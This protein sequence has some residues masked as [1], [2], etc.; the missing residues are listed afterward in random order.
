MAMYAIKDTTL[1]ALG[2]AVRN[3]AG[4]Y[5]SVDEK[6]EPFYEITGY[7]TDLE[8]VGYDSMNVRNWY[9]TPLIDFRTIPRADIADKWYIEYSY[10]CLDVAGPMQSRIV[11]TVGDT[12]VGDE[13]INTMK[14]IS[15]I[16]VGKTVP[17]KSGNTSGNVLDAWNKA[18]LEVGMNPDYD[19][20]GQRILFNV[21]IWACDANDKFIEL[22]KY[23]PLEMA[24]KV[25]E[26]MTIPDEALN[27]TG[28][29]SYRFTNNNWNWF[30]EQAGDKI[31]TNGITAT[32][33]M[34]SQC[35]K[36]KSIP[37]EININNSSY[38]DLSYMFDYCVAL[39]ELPKINNAYPSGL[40]YFCRHCHNVREIP[41]DYF[42][43]WNFN[44]LHS[45]SYANMSYMFAYMNSVRKIP[46]NV[47]KNLWSPATTSSYALYCYGFH[48]CYYL[49][50]LVGLPVP[51]AKYTSNVF[52]N[53]FD[54]CHR[55]KDV[56]FQ[57]NEDGTP[58]VAPWNKQ[59]IN[60]SVN[61]G[62][63]PSSSPDFY[64]SGIT[65]DKLITTNAEYEALKDDPDATPVYLQWSRYNHDSAVRTINSL[66]DCS[67]TGTNTI[68]FSGSSGA[69]TDG[70]AI[71]TL[72]EEEIAVATAKGWTVSM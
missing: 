41:E 64:N 52:S 16:A 27:I 8:F 12:P 51:P 50:E 30:I 22:N 11:F 23:T 39:E 2:D 18:Y 60:L 20:Q 57:T 72:T 29:C 33:S 3:K 35:D 71:N 68:K 48:S 1:T 55:L 14:Y 25:N 54:Q 15:I 40:G 62:Y 5:I 63:N 44:R 19:S 10:E 32:V 28:D 24:E 56:I 37:F 13:L 61:V 49:D 6:G 59:T 34:F 65:A 47:L 36:L 43:N 9:I 38:K 42:D 46:A 70:R 45:Y 53:T 7:T 66:P 26:L 69:N 58:I 4:K 17:T 31:T 67:A 21:K